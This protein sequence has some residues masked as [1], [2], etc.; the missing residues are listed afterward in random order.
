MLNLIMTHLSNRI[1]YVRDPIEGDV[2]SDPVEE[3]VENRTSL[4]E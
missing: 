1:I 4:S 3:D 2:V